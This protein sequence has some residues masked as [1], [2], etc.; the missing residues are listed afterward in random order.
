MERKDVKWEEI[1]EK[2]RELFALE[3]QYYQEKKKLDNK[4]LD[5]D[6]RNANL[7]KLISEEVDKMSH[8]L[9]KFE[10]S[11]DDVGDYFTEIENLR[12]FSN[13]VYRDRR[14]K[15]EDEREKYDNEFRK[16]R[17]DLDEE[18]QYAL[19]QMYRM[20]ERNRIITEAKLAITAK[21]KL[22]DN[23]NK[24]AKKIATETKSTIT[25]INSQM[26]TAIQGKVR[27]S[28][29]EKIPNMLLKYDEI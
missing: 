14:I 5:L 3:D 26:D 4:A 15:L 10:T 17:N 27:K 11:V 1:R 13:Q 7:E 12:H 9:R 2:E 22:K 25:S 28:L 19:K 6:E 23:F 21:N 29:E 16:K 20:M 24:A 8:I 18:Y